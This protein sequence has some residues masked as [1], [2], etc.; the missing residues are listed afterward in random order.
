M[1]STW[2]FP[3]AIDL[4]FKSRGSSMALRPPP[5]SA[6]KLVPTETQ[7]ATDPSGTPAC[8][9]ACRSSLQSC[10]LQGSRWAGP[11]APAYSLAYPT[12]WVSAKGAPSWP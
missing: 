1:A 8:L 7:A 11:L 4:L 10:R 6:Q 5:P 3:I 2:L 9:L 12:R